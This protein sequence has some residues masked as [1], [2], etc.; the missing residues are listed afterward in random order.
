MV[1]MTE[2]GM[3]HRRSSKPYKYRR[4]MCPNHDGSGLMPCSPQC[5]GCKWEQ[6][7][8]DSLG[9]PPPPRGIPHSD[10]QSGGWDRLKP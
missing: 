1:G 5:T 2:D 7:Q 9:P 4:D 10:S 3:V 8:I 6:A